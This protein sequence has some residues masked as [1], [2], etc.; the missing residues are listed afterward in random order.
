MIVTLGRL[1]TWLSTLKPQQSRDHFQAFQGTRVRWKKSSN[2]RPA[3][4]SRTSFSKFISYQ[5]T[6]FKGSLIS[7]GN[8]TLVPLPIE[9]CQITPLIRKFEY[10][11]YCLGAE[12]SNS[13]LS[14]LAPFL[15]NG[16]K[17]KIPSD[18]Q[19]PLLTLS[20]IKREKRILKT[21]FRSSFS[22][23]C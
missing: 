1:R 17:I 5:M 11:V 22:Q 19:P 23:K 16:T 7:E 3:M 21:F 18:M 9:R 14:N 2:I 4:K 13:L 20:S 15:G 12:N 8:L 6:L 10:V